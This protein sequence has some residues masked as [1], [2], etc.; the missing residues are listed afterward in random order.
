ME[1]KQP[2]RLNFDEYIAL[3]RST[4]IRHEYHDGTVYAMAGGTLAHSMISGNTFGELRTA[5]KGKG[6]DCRPFNSDLKLH[7]PSLNKFLYPDVMVVC[8]SIQSEGA[9]KGISNPSVI[10]EVLSKSTET[11]DRGKKF[12]YYRQIPSLKTYILIHQYAAQ[13]EIFTRVSDLWKITLI[14]GINQQIAIDTLD[15]TLNMKDIYEDVA[16]E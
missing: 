4:N 12:Y 6:S 15:I 8:G 2:D 1:V 5:L 16:F 14:E 10:I 3:E 7:I 13:V 11:Y 9:Y